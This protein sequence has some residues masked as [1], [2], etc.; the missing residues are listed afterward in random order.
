M[1]RRGKSCFELHELS[2]E[3]IDLN[4]TLHHPKRTDPDI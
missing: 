3:I 1:K 2:K 4:E